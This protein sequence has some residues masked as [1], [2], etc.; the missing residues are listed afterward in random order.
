MIDSL[1][2]LR[3]SLFN[4]VIYSYQKFDEVLW[5][6]GYNLRKNLVMNK[7]KANI[8]ILKKATTKEHFL[9][10][11]LEIT[12]DDWPKWTFPRSWSANTV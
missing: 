4:L 3:I 7:I 9:S 8:Y 1:K 12:V 6:I 2:Y 11:R 10:L 5:K